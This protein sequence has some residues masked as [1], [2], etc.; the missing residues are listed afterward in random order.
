MN[1]SARIWLL[2]M[3][4][5][6]LVGVLIHFL[7]PL[8]FIITSNPKIEEAY[9]SY[10]IEVEQNTV[11]ALAFL[12]S[13]VANNRM[14]MYEN[15]RSTFIRLFDRGRNIQPIDVDQVTLNNARF[16]AASPSVAME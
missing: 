10:K 2:F 1:R 13:K 16:L 4:V 6:F 7:V 8:Q 15:I 3:M 11:R 12:N 5:P 9:N 14:Q